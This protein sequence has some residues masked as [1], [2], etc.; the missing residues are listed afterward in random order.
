MSAWGGDKGDGIA[1]VA[2]MAGCGMWWIWMRVV[3]DAVA[4]GVR[5]IGDFKGKLLWWQG[6]SCGVLDGGNGGIY[7][8]VLRGGTRMEVVGAGRKRGEGGGWVMV[9]GWVCHS[10]TRCSSGLYL[11]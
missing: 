10:S 9:G 4:Y 5:D 6:G 2:W 3:E 11:S 7:K 1:E 8:L